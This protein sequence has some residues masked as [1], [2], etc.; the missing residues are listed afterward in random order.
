MAGKNR[1]TN[2]SDET[3]IAS[4]LSGDAIFSI[5]YFQ[6][7][8]K[9]KSERL[10]Q[11]DLDILGLVDESSDFH[12]LGAMIVHG[13]RSNPSDPDLY[14]VI[15]RQQRITT[16]FLYICAAVRFLSKLGAHAE[17]IGLLLKYLVIN[18]DTKTSNL[19]LHPGKDDRE[20][21]NAVF[22]ELISDAKLKALL[23]GFK[24]KRL[25]THMQS[26]STG[27]LRNNFRHALGFFDQEFKQ[28]GRERV[29]QIYA[30]LLNKMSV[31]QI[32]VKDPTSG[33]KIFDSL[34]SRQEPMTVGDLIRNEIFS[35]V[36]DEDPDEIERIDQ[37]HWQPFYKKF[38]QGGRN[39][40]D[41]YFFPFGLIGNPNLKKSDVYGHLRKQ[42]AQIKDPSQIIVQLSEYQ[43]DFLDVENGTN[44]RGQLPE[45][46]RAFRQLWSLGAP[47]STFPFLMQ[48]SNQTLKETVTPVNCSK[49]LAVVEFFLV[50]RA[51]CGIEP[52][53][54]HSVFKRLWGACGDEIAAERITEEISQHKTVLWPGAADF[55]NS[56]VSRPLYGVSITPFLLR[57]YDKSLGGEVPENEFYVEHILPQTPD[58][59]WKNLF[60]EAQA[61]LY[62][63]TLANLVPL[64]GGV[65]ASLGNKPYPVKRERYESDAMFKSTPSV[66]EQYSQWTPVELTERSEVLSQWAAARWPHEPKD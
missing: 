62:T 53:G 1:L 45:I 2:N 48:L 21:L 33:P 60:S 30:N 38:E 13:R 10:R 14:D 39:V 22:E 17:A 52:T 56:I 20:Q 47:S 27:V 34:N 25:P 28:G 59:I 24:F 6:R 26:K 36:A 46:S 57:E 18:R 7:P 54:L 9:W 15:D 49:I 51:V 23:G 64:S 63:D 35:R 32:D 61:K 4:L 65:N 42:W 8:Y 31:V 40:F 44:L 5:P 3:D 11:L 50:R 43:N 19:K 29:D 41:K 37:E 12:F 66:A 55:R 16:L 58:G